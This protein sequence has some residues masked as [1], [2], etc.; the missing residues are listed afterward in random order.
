MLVHLHFG[1]EGLLPWTL[2]IGMWLA[3]AASVVWRPAVGLYLLA[4]AL[5]LQTG[6]YKIHDFFLGSQFVDLLLLGAVL[7]L[8]F[9]GQPLSP[10]LPLNRYLLLFAVFLYFSLWEGSYFVGSPLPLWI[11]DARFSGWKNYVEM[12]LLAS[13]VACAVKE[14]RQ[15]Q[16]LI[17]TMCLSA[18]VVNRNYYSLLSGRDLTVFSED[19]RD[20]GLL[21]YAGVNGLAAFEA[22]LCSFL[23]GLFV[24]TKRLLPKIGLAFVIASG[25]YCLLFSFSRGGYIGFLV[26]MIA[27]GLLKSRKLLVIALL[28]MVGWQLILPLSVQQRIAMTTGTPAAGAQFDSSSEERLTLWRD[29]LEL[30]E[31]NPVT[32]T[33]FNTYKLLNRVGSFRD[34]HNYYVKVLVETGLVGM[35][36]F[37]ILLYRLLGVGRALRAGANDPF[38]SGLGL[39]FVA[40]IACAAALNLFGDRWDYQQVDGYLWI[41]LGCSMRGLIIMRETQDITAPELLGDLKTDE[42]ALVAY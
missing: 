22:M 37:M 19:V 28:L 9:K 27:L 40:L 13:V 1:A 5:P 15:V 38:W 20:A 8:L 39:A 23:L 41:I 36:L 16:F 2:Y 10:R 31:R 24:S 33:G 29:A 42:L 7:G 17:V 4:F 18:L 30:F 25:I 35:V 32:G 3:F 34:T 11:T 14:K 12:F 21:G 6:R 26:G